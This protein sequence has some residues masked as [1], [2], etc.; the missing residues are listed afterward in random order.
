MLQGPVSALK[1]TNTAVPREITALHSL[2][3]AAVSIA[4]ISLF[5]SNK[6]VP[7]TTATSNLPTWTTNVAG[8]VTCLTGNNKV[9]VIGCA[10][11]AIH[12]LDAS[13][14]MRLLSPI[15]LGLGVAAVDLKVDNEGNHVLL[16][17]TGDGEIYVWNFS[18]IKLNFELA[19]QF[20]CNIKPLIF[21]IKS[22]QINL[23]ENASNT[24]TTA[25]TSTDEL[26]SAC[27]DKCYLY[28]DQKGRLLPTVH[29]RSMIRNGGTGGDL[30]V[31]SYVPTTMAWT[32]VADARHVLSGVL[33]YSTSLSAAVDGSLGKLEQEA[34]AANLLAANEVISL[35]SALN[36]SGD[37]EGPQ[38]LK[39]Y[40]M[41]TSISH[42]EERMLLSRSLGTTEEY[43]YWMGEWV[44]VC[45]KAGQTDKVKWCV[46]Q[47][48]TEKVSNL[49]H[50]SESESDIVL[51]REII[52]P[53]IARVPSCEILLES[54]HDSVS[55]V[56]TE[57]T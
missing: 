13:S 31:F 12:V 45:C 46:N 42:C 8:Q 20:K 5:S 51:V 16:A 43:R 23:S 25:Q 48:L 55:F 1:A 44:T 21:S 10:D 52:L 35:S 18:S 38:S 28:P 36:R 56:L 6:S 39:N 15:I 34:S 50:R 19:C 24:A 30:Q 14:G 40:I 49:I 47:L 27:A 4:T 57:K 9:A 11:G 32:R 41:N 22:K 3:H 2:P 7:V 53:A 37:I 33:G 26:V 29:I 17:L 54:L